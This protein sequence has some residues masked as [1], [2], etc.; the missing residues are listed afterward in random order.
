MLRPPRSRG[1]LLGLA[2]GAACAL[3]VAA[4]YAAFSGADKGDQIAQVMGK[5]TYKYA[6]WGLL[7][8]DPRSGRT[9]RAIQPAKE[10]IPGSVTKVFTI[11]TAWNTLGPGHRFTTPVYALGSTQDSTLTG[12]LVLQAQGDLTMGGRTTPKG[13]VDFRIYDHLDSPGLPRTKLTPENPLA[14]LNKIAQQVHDAGITQVQGDVAI[15]D[16]LWK[17]DPFLTGLDPQ[18][19]PIMINDNVIDVQVKPTQPG[20]PAQVLWRPQTAAIQVHAQVTT[21]PPSD[22]PGFFP[23]RWQLAQPSADSVVASGTIPANAGAQLQI[24]TI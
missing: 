24:A 13:Q 4:G 20:Q 23:Y 3:V 11:S 2:I 17:P 18:L 6:Q 22:N 21:G 16:R 1:L 15:D 7:E 9:V 14:G 8:K 12:N 10:F 19:D 5:P